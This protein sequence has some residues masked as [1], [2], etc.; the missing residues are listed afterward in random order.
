M[1]YLWQR[2]REESDNSSYYFLDGEGDVQHRLSYLE[3]H[4]QAC[5]IA[6][7]LRQKLSP[8]ERCLLLFPQ[9]IDFVIAFWGCLYARV[10]PLPVF[11]PT[12]SQQSSRLLAIIDDS[13][14]QLALTNAAFKDKCLKWLGDA[15]E[16]KVELCVLD[17]LQKNQQGEDG[18]AFINE[19][20]EDDLAFIQYSSGSTGA[21]KGVPI[22]HRELLEN[23]EQIRQCFH[24]TK[25]TIGANWLPLYHNMGLVGHLLCPIYVGC[26]QYFFGAQDFLRKPKL[27]LEVIGRNQV[28]TSGAPN[29]AYQYCI[30]RIN[31]HDLN[32]LDLSCW[33]QAYCGAEPVQ[34]NTL[35]DFHRRFATVGFR[36]EALLPCYGLAETT[37]S[38]TGFK[39]KG[40]IANTLEV[41]KSELEQGL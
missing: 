19:W 17:D 14:A 29:F 9:G 40:L 21:P 4:H 39:P 12:K 35:Q 22:F 13:Q 32:G 30:D 15:S 41:D 1:T 18:W 27:W 38:V 26:Q 7:A 2:S 8:G 3:L 28:T 34:A 36:Q 31:D 24:L 33:V 25:E 10:V 11:P 16:S 6:H 20:S 37:L 5:A 23:L